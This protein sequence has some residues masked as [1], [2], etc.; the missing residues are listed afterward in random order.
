MTKYKYILENSQIETKDLSTIPNGVSYEEVNESE[1]QPTQEEIFNERVLTEF[2]YYEKRKA[3]GQDAVLM[4]ESKLRV[5][6]LLGVITEES[7]KGIDS[8]LEPIAIAVERGQWIDGRDKLIALGSSQIG[9]DMYD[10]IY[11]QINDYI[12]ENY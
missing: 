8:L 12:N 2:S 1:E 5:L 4:L 3:D 6:K 10:S 11:T 9:Q 7:H